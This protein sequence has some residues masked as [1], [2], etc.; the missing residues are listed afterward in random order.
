MQRG[1]WTAKLVNKITDGTKVLNYWPVDKEDNGFWLKFLDADTQKFYKEYY[2]KTLK[3]EM[4]DPEN[5][6]G[7]RVGYGPKATFKLK[8]STP[9]TSTTVNG[10]TKVDGRQTLSPALGEEKVCTVSVN[11]GASIENLGFKY[12]DGTTE[13]SF[14]CSI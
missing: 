1:N 4:Y 7:T 14:R 5:Q 8:V 6:Y 13:C 2:G 12:S 9:I 10:V 11:S 3:V